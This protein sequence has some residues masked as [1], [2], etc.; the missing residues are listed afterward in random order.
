[1]PQDVVRVQQ[2]MTSAVV[3]GDTV[4]TSVKKK[5][6][7][8]KIKTEGGAESQDPNSQGTLQK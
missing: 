7:K 4:V 1:M 2:D 6:K 5:K 3:A 8:K